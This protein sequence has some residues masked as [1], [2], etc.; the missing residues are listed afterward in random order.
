M[1]S[2]SRMDRLHIAFFGPTNS[3][4]ST[5]VNALAGQQVSLVSPIPGTTTDPVRKTIEL[6]GLGPCVLIDTAGLGDGSA[7]GAERERLTRAILDETDIAVILEVPELS[8][9]SQI[10]GHWQ[11][12]PGE[13]ASNVPDFG[14]LAAQA[15]IP[16]IRYTRGESVE[17][18]LDR[19]VAVAPKEE[20]RYLTGSLVGPGSSVLLVMPQDSEAPKGRLILP[21]VQVL[22]ELLDRGCVPHCCTPAS[23]PAALESL[24]RR[25]DLVITDS[26]VF[27]MVNRALPADCPLTSFSVLLAA[28]KGDI[29]TF[30]E[31]ARAIDTL[32]P[33]SRVLIAEA[34]THVPDTE[35]IGRVKIPALLR[36]KAGEIKVDIAAGNDFPEDLSPYSLVIHCGACVANAR[37]VRSRIRKALLAGV[38]ITNYGIALAALNGILARIV[39]P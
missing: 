7:L 8:P 4:K 19:L 12:K 36:K 39:L 35:D 15:G 17:S 28:A 16:V 9:M 1:I 27:G 11:Q 26:Q 34:C 20:Q 38:P 29:R 14:T 23:L 24:S 25:P 10:S 37:L 2:A 13:N 6:P 32:R 3:G 31:G 30:V 22:R 5:L 33:G 21:Q 18:L